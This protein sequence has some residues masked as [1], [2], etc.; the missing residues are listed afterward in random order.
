MQNTD[1]SGILDA[2]TST[3]GKASMTTGL[4]L[5][6]EDMFDAMEWVVIGC[7]SS[8]GWLVRCTRAGVAVGVCAASEVERHVDQLES[9]LVHPQY[10][11]NMAFLDGYIFYVAIVRGDEQTR[12]VASTAKVEPRLMRLT[13]VL[14]D[15]TRDELMVKLN[16]S[17]S[18]T[19]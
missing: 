12:H 19:P 2:L 14:L 17:R 8:G 13:H 10:D 3:F 4:M 1:G 7:D 18:P 6:R 16:E 9:A 15:L 11:E 5:V